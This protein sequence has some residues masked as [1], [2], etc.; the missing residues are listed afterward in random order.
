MHLGTYR[1]NF[2]SYLPCPWMFTRTPLL[3]KTTDYHFAY[4]CLKMLFKVHHRLA[5]LCFQSLNLMTWE[6]ERTWIQFHF[7]SLFM[8]DLSI[9]VDFVLFSFQV[10]ASV[11]LSKVTWYLSTFMADSLWWPCLMPCFESSLSHQSCWR[12]KWSDVMTSHDYMKTIHRIIYILIF[13]SVIF[14]STNKHGSAKH[15]WWYRYLYIDF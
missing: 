15:M 9:P 13:T 3:V 4:L 11:L 7:C 12:L 10:I 8:R 5:F 14:F 1:N 6:I 2:R